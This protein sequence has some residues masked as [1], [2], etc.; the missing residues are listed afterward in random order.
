MI[1]AR[2]TLFLLL[3]GC[4]YDRSPHPI[5]QRAYNRAADR[6]AGLSRKERQ[7]AANQAAWAAKY[8]EPFHPLTDG[9]DRSLEEA[10]STP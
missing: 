3:T 5:E 10:L 9:R 8:P 4:A 1:V 2:L 7:S 6:A